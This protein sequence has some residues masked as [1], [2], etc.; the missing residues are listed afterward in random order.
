MT[1]TTSP[2]LPLLSIT[3]VEPDTNDERAAA[4]EEHDR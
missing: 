4:A 1:L 3:R 2:G